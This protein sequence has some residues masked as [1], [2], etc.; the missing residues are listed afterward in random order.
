DG[1]DRDGPRPDTDAGVGAD[2]DG[3]ATDAPLDGAGDSTRDGPPPPDTTIDGSLDSTV[4][5]SLDSTVDGQGGDSS[6]DSTVDGQGGDSSVDGTVDGGGGGVL[7][8]ASCDQQVPGITSADAYRFAVGPGPLD[9]L[10]VTWLDTSPAPGTINDRVYNGSWNSVSSYTPGPTLQAGDVAMTANG[11]RHFVYLTLTTL[12]Y[13]YR[14]PSGAW[15]ELG[16]YGPGGFASKPRVA[17]LH[18]TSGVV[19]AA[20]T[21]NSPGT[22]YHVTVVAAGNG[23]TIG[24]QATLPISN[25]GNFAISGSSSGSFGAASNGLATGTALTARAPLTSTM[26]L[27]GATPLVESNSAEPGLY[28]VGTS[29]YLAAVDSSGNLQLVE[30]QFAGNKLMPGPSGHQVK[31]NAPTAAGTASTFFDGSYMVVVW[32]EKVGV[33]QSLWVARDSSSGWRTQLLRSGPV[34]QDTKRTRSIA[35]VN[36]NAYVAYEWD[37]TLRAYCLTKIP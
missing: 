6:L 22:A 35:R 5:G 33:T 31:A 11:D 10:V 13:G 16:A 18:G 27:S 37:G 4:D 36:G 21:A 19:L 30:M 26:L 7:F 15:T 2:G 34:T 20:T 9:E 24:S 17:R 25:I 14:K 3:P 23:Y 28:T 1:P 12:I 29:G 8:S 32:Q